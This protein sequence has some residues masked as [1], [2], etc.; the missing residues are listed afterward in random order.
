MKES[1]N[2]FKK[3]YKCALVTGGAGF[4]GSHLTEKLVAEGIETKVLDNFST[5]RKE[6]L[7]KCVDKENFSLF[8]LDLGKLGD[9]DDF[10]ENVEVV[11]HMAANP[12]VRGGNDNPE[13]LFEQNTVN[14]FNLLQRIKHSKVRRIVFASTSA[15]YGNVRTLPTH[16]GYGPLYPISHYGASKLSC[17][18]MISSFCYN[19]D[20][21][22]IILRPANVIGSRFHRGLIWDLIHKLKSDK[23]RL[24]VLGDGKQ[25]KSF[26]HISDM[27]KGI[28][29]SMRKEENG[30]DIFNMGSEDR[31][32]I[33]NVAKIVCKNMKLPN[34][35]IFTTG[36]AENGGGWMGDMKIVHLDISKLKNMG[37]AP[38][39]SSLEAVDLT[40]QEIMDEGVMS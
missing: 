5:G 11:F 18:A 39:L 31:V 28:F 34:V 8:D 17:E 32:D 9:R 26:I 35:E 15:V 33:I 21:D 36:G 1:I 29:Q 16:E 25:S 22:A 3:K 4:I 23:N 12:E 37:W 38:K 6:N 30:V 10:L 24:E 20:M 14:T 19:Y 13:I 27:I 2:W 40:S 7:L